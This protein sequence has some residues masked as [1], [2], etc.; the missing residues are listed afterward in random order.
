MKKTPLKRKTRLRPRSKKK[1]AEMVIYNKRK[2]AY[3]EALSEKQGRACLPPYC[4]CFGSPHIAIDWHHV[5]PK[6][7]GGKQNQEQM[8]AVSREAH[9]WITDHPKEAEAKGWLL[10]K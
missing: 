1:A 2:K 10:T 6:G 7:R 4:E 9:R 8:L 5:L 3:F